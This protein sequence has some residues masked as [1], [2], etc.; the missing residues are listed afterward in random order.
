M[1]EVIVV[2]AVWVFAAVA[3]AIMKKIDPENK[4]YAIWTILVCI[5]LTLFVGWYESWWIIFR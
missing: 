2:L 1:A 4:V 5:L 3:V